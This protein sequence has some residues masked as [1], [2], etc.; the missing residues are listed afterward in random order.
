MSKIIE[1]IK[2]GNKVTT[3]ELFE[4]V[5]LYKC[6]QLDL[7][8]GIETVMSMQVNEFTK[9]GNL[10]E[11][12]QKCTANTNSYTLDKEDVLLSRVDWDEKED[13]LFIECELKNNMELKMIIQL[14]NDYKGTEDYHETDIC[15]IKDFLEDVLH[16]RNEYYCVLARVKNV[17]GLDLKMNSPIRA[18]VNALDEYECDWR[19]H[20]N[21][22]QSE[23]EVLLSNAE[24]LFF[25]IDSINR[26]YWKETDCSIEILVEPYGQSFTEI[27]LLFFK[28]H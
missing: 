24:S 3:E 11:F 1:A 8:I 25:E 5:N 2:M 13:A 16:E 6:T 27:K 4:V 22:N 15:N 14:S 10:Y 17:F 12:S 7:L 20:I 19:L 26:F 23:L 28:K 9:Y 18:Y 21:N